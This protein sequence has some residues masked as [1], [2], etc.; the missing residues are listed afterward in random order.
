MERFGY[1]TVGCDRT[2]ETMVFKAGKPCTAKGCKCGLPAI[3][4]SE[5]DFEGYNDAGAATLGHRK[6][7]AKW[8]RKK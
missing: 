1:E 7:V 8:R 4:G 3:D 2:Y 5:L 6:M